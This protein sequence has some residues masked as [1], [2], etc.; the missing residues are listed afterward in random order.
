[1]ITITI[2]SLHPFVN[3]KH[4][5]SGFTHMPFQNKQYKMLAC[6]NYQFQQTLIFPS[7]TLHSS[8]ISLIQAIAF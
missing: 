3:L 4:G 7:T 5:G 8:N 6:R 1:M 2:N